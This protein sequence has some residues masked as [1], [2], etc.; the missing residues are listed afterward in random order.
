VAIADA[1]LRGI[2][3]ES[4]RTNRCLRSEEFDN[5]AWV[6][7]NMT[8]TPNLIPAP[9]GTITAD[10]LQSTAANGTCIQDLGVVA[11]AAKTGSIWLS[12]R[13]G[14]GAIQLT[15]DGGAG[16]TT[17]VP[18]VTPLWGRFSLSQTL[19]NEDFGIRFVDSG[20]MCDVWGGQVE[21]AVAANAVITS[22]I[23]TTTAA[24]A[25]N[26]E[27]MFYASAGNISAAAGTAYC[28]F[29][30]QPP[31]W[32]ERIVGEGTNALITNSGNLVSIQDSGGQALSAPVVTGTFTRAASTWLSGGNKQ[33]YANGSSAGP[34]VFAGFAFATFPL[35]GNGADGAANTPFRNVRIWNGVQPIGPAGDVLSTAGLI[36]RR[37]GL[38]QR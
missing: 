38:R 35:S 34:Q 26:D 18:P 28:E 25:R 14:A 8:V 32:N 2:L 3:M 13:A 7:T 6:K 4:G 31:I 29:T 19:A 17:V 23:P 30:M 12:R 20:D 9:D 21:S 36:W 15:M 27:T 11:S 22:Y 5:A 1:T 33:A 24:V 37:R 10:V 16:W